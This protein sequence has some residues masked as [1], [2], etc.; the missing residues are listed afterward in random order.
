MVNCQVSAWTSFTECSTTCGRGVKTRYRDI[1]QMSSGGGVACPPFENLQQSIPCE[2]RACYFWNKP[3]LDPATEAADQNYIAGVSD[4]DSIAGNEL[5]KVID[6]DLP[7]VD[8]MSDQ[9]SSPTTVHGFNQTKT[10]N[11][12]TDIHPSTPTAGSDM[13]ML[14]QEL[15]DEAT[16]ADAIYDVDVE[17]SKKVSPDPTHSTIKTTPPGTP[18][19]LQRPFGEQPA[20]HVISTEEPFLSQSKTASIPKS[21]HEKQSASSASTEYVH[22]RIAPSIT[23][24]QPFLPTRN[25][26]SAQSVKQNLSASITPLATSGKPNP[27]RTENPV[28]VMLTTYL[29]N[30]GIT[31]N[32]SRNDGIELLVENVGSDFSDTTTTVVL[33]VA[34]IVGILFVTASFMVMARHWYGSGRR[35]RLHTQM[36]YLLN[37]V[38]D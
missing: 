30:T 6:E 34:L 25:S 24:K 37:D 21:G 32:E 18:E 15:M 2:E 28:S 38:S 19:T 1:V 8:R 20:V 7:T 3:I 26:E 31:E 4:T 29:T 14:E 33:V 12:T 23:H 35:R 22:T 16:Q 17:F 36:E 5:D 11:T 9:T 13:Q 10:M 27:L